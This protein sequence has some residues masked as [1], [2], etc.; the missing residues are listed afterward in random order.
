M[1]QRVG[2]WEHFRRG[3]ASVQMCR[4]QI[5]D[6]PMT[7]VPPG[8]SPSVLRLV[9]ERYDSCRLAL[10]FKPQK[11]F[12]I[13]NRLRDQVFAYHLRKQIVDDL[14]RQFRIDRG[15]AVNGGYDD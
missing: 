3:N 5:L 6:A 15:V 1:R 2:P 8:G 13:L 7:L 4:L 10:V 12:R 11:R 14:S 9:E